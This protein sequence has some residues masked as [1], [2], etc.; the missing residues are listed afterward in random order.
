MAE[1]I[2]LLVCLQLLSCQIINQSGNHYT[3]VSESVIQSTVESEVKIQSTAE[4]KYEMQFTAESEYTVQ[5]T[6]ESEYTVQSTTESQLTMHSTAE[7]EYTVQSTTESQLTMHST[8][9]SE[10]TLQSTTESESET[11][12]TEGHSSSTHVKKLVE[13]QSDLTTVSDTKHDPRDQSPLK[14]TERITM[15]TENETIETKPGTL[16][17]VIPTTAQATIV[18]YPM[19]STSTSTKS[20]NL[21]SSPTVTPGA[22]RTRRPMKKSILDIITKETLSGDCYM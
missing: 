14:N 1:F 16:K 10:Y 5:S 21:E 15:V 12:S 17:T 20:L 6:T 18:S 7:S 13:S 3:A 22:F 2:V 8:A 11:Q 4:S 19:I 9:E